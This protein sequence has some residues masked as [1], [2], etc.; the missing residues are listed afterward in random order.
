MRDSYWN[1]NWHHT[2]T[3]QNNDQLSPV[4]TSS[5]WTIA[6][7]HLIRLHQHSPLKQKNTK[8]CASLSQGGRATEE[9]NQSDIRQWADN[10]PSC[11]WFRAWFHLRLALIWGDMGHWDLI[12]FG[13]NRIAGGVLKGE[14]SW[15]EIGSEWFVGDMRGWRY[16]GWQKIGGGLYI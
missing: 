4:D 14:L 11:D 6:W 13:D 7:L 10:T 16:K 12:I 8:T 9:V 5:P 1:L 2:P 15:W 3:P